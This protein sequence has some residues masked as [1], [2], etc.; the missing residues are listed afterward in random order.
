MM[1]G[2]TFCNLMY[3]LR[4][5]PCERHS[6]VTPLDRPLPDDYLDELAYDIAEQ[7]PDFAD[8][9]VRARKRKKDDTSDPG[10]HP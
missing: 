9:I 6:Q 10:S 7:H 2:C 1:R 3:L 8:K 4:K 5:H